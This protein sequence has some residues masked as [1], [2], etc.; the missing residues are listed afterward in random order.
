MALLV[1]VGGEVSILRGELDHVYKV[2]LAVF[3]HT[4]L[5]LQGTCEFQLLLFFCQNSGLL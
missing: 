4:A 5:E 2:S 3:S 1:E